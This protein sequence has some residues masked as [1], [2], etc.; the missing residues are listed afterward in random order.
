MV[1][2][3]VRGRMRLDH[4]NE[5][6]PVTIGD[7]VSVQIQKDKTGVITEVSERRNCL[8]RRASGRKVGKR[9]ILV[10]NVDCIW[11][12]QSARQ[13]RLNTGLVDRLLVACEAQ[14]IPAGIL[15]NKT[16]LVSWHHLPSIE[17]IANSYQYLGYPVIL[18]S[19]EEPQNIDVLREQLSG[20][21]SV[22][23]GPSGAGKSSLLNAMDPDIN[24]PVETISRKTHK[25]RHTTAHAA[26]YPLSGGGNVADTPGIREFGLLDIE[27]W[28]L[29]H[30]FPEFRP[31]LENCRY[32]ACTHDHEPDCGVKDARGVEMISA[33][34]YESYLNILRSLQLGI[35]DTG[36]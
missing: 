8:Y 19:V 26:L 28:E 32:S 18:T 9:Q 21:I 1:P 4:E 20:K 5:T 16:D 35:S 33:A 3:R 2:S 17:K 24:I 12:V 34:R 27:P 36:R 14:E 31:H 22:F 6:Q 29:A 7:H 11:I 30:Y 13:P 15:I 10:A 23:M 25:G